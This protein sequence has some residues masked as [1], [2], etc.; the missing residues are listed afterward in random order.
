MRN[1]GRDN[2]K[3]FI[4]QHW[5][6][7]PQSERWNG[8]NDQYKDKWVHVAHIYTG[9][10]A[11]SRVQLYFNGVM[12]NNWVRTQINTTQDNSNQCKLQLGRWT[13]WDN[14]RRTMNGMLD[15]FRIYAKAL[16]ASEIGAIYNNGDGDGAVPPNNVFSIQATQNANRFTA[17]G[18]PAGLLLDDRTGKIA[19]ATTVITM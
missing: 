7:D 6:W 13:T 3:R 5:C 10:N 4:S 8:N 14:E 16:D 12:R 17:A 9:S 11:D 19:G 18:L 15:D 1:L 2:Y